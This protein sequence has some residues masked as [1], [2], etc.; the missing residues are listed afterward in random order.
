MIEF[1]SQQET[2][3]DAAREECLA[4]AM[5][6]LA[7]VE[8]MVDDLEQTLNVNDSVLVGNAILEVLNLRFYDYVVWMEGKYR[9]GDQTFE[10]DFSEMLDDLLQDVLG[11]M[12]EGK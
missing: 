5:E 3:Q 8:H 7:D 10:Y 2:Y 1:E 4:K 9:D 11:F 12:K 6:I